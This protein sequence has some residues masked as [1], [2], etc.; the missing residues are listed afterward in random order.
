MTVTPLFWLF[1]PRMSPIYPNSF[2]SYPSTQCQFFG[3]TGFP[4][5]IPKPLTKTTEIL[6]QNSLSFMGPR[7]PVGYVNANSCFFS[8]Q[9]GVMNVGFSWGVT[10]LILQLGISRWGNPT[11][12]TTAGYV[13]AGL[14]ERDAESR[15]ASRCRCWVEFKGDEFKVTR[16]LP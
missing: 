8:L 11:C 13:V 15:R 12:S 6:S 1:I 3:A 5:R 16:N 9:V 4:T 2:G 14:K 10:Y 7:K